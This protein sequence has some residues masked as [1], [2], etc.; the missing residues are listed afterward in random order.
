MNSVLGNVNLWNDLDFS[1]YAVPSV[2]YMIT[3]SDDWMKSKIEVS[4]DQ[5]VAIE[6]QK[7]SSIG[8]IF[9]NYQ[10]NKL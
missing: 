1:L 3:T 2:C 10:T 5:C 9:V 6:Y 8:I 4:A 7:L